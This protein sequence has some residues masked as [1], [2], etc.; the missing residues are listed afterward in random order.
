MAE[1]KMS[2]EQAKLVAQAQQRF[3]AFK[4]TN[5]SLDK[6]GLDLLFSEAR[7]QNGWQDRPVDDEILRELYDLTR[8]G[9][10]SL[11]CC[12][13]RF[14]FVRT[15]AGRERIKPTLWPMN[16]HKIMTAPVVVIIAYD[17][18]FLKKLG[19]LFPHKPDVGSM[20]ADNTDLKTT[21]AIR[22]GTLQGAY[23]M[24]AARSLGLDCGPISG[25]DNDA[26]DAEFFADSPIKSNFICA[27]GYGDPAKFFQRLPRLP[28]DE[29]CELA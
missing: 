9:A 22:N 4:A 3:A 20:F 17:V 26:I 2:E 6:V 19:V 7:S 23:L 16:V 29:A 24:L 14:V 27:L 10:T 21:T 15:D 8:M 28:F 1:T 25:F 13:A 5:P 11:N 18:E 12:P